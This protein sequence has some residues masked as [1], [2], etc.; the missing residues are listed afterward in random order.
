MAP[1]SGLTRP[2]RQRNI[3]IPEHLNITYGEPYD[4]VFKA[5]ANGAAMTYDMGNYSEEILRPVKRITSYILVN[6]PE[7]LFGFIMAGA[8]FFERHEGPRMLIEFN[9]RVMAALKL[10]A[11]TTYK[12]FFNII[13]RLPAVDLV[14]IALEMENYQLLNKN[15]NLTVYTDFYWDK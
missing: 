5:W 11:I 7:Q 14:Y 6:H 9:N 3:D 13:Y 2:A 8:D 4:T 15:S 12:E 1:H 10:P